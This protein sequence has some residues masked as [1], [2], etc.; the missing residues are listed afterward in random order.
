MRIGN[1]RQLLVE[2]PASATG[3]IAFNLIVFFLVCASVQPD[4]GIKQSIPSSEEVEEESQQSE[5]IEVMLTRSAVAINGNFVRMNQFVPQLQRLL[6][7]KTRDE[8]RVVVVKSRKDVPYHHWIA[9]TS[10]I[11]EAV[12]IITLQIEEEREIQIPGS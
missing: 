5:N 7:D 2:P 1:R 6:A 9:V 12:G 4:S 3:D 10:R 8:Q 11:E